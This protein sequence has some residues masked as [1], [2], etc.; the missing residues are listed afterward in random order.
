VCPA[1]FDQHARV[2]LADPLF[3][4][5]GNERRTEHYARHVLV[6][7]HGGL[8]IDE[9]WDWRENY[10]GPAV[11]EMILRYGWPTETLTG[12]PEKW[13]RGNTKSVF[14]GDW[15]AVPSYPDGCDAI[16]FVRPVSR[17]WGPQ[18]HTF[19]DWETTLDPFHATD[20]GWDLAAPRDGKF[21]DTSWWAKEFYRRDAGALVPL[22]SQSAFFRRQQTAILAAA[23]EWDTVAYLAKPRD[24]MI[25]AALVSKGP[26]GPSGG[27]TDTMSGRVPRPL[28][29]RVPSGE[30]LLAIEM[31]PRNASGAAA[32][33][34]MGVTVPPPLSA[35]RPGELALSDVV[36]ARVD[37]G[38]DAPASMAALLPRMLGSTRL[39]EPKRVA[40][41]WE[42]Y[43]LGTGDTVDVDLRLIR[44]DDTGSVA[45]F[46]T[47]LGLANSGEDTITTSWREPR[48]GEP[49]ATVEGGVTIRPR[50]LV[51]DM[52]AYK[53]GRYELAILVRRGTQPPA[54]GRREFRIER[55]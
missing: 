35:I 51:I 38:Q 52:T 20:R 13:R 32:R 49:T 39:R 1:R 22:A 10:Q 44:R 26:N 45:H 23:M 5:N 40:L 48:S 15:S 33:T 43:G 4:E 16:C 47:L 18:F 7:L 34:R 27:V 42:L 37:A 8:E 11:R 53:E 36:L 28:V 6:D 24:Q 17:Y 12:Q 19:A 30:G 29:T 21:W 3:L 50:G 14:L 9:H 41:F 31:I 2:W 55:R 54:I 25:A 46:L